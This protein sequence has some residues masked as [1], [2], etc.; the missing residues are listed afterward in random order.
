MYFSGVYA[1]HLKQ[2]GLVTTSRAP[3]PRLENRLDFSRS[4]LLHPTEA[5]QLQVH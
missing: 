1:F 3:L 4:L 5:H 2:S